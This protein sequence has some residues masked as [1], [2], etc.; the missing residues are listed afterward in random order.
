MPARPPSPAL[1]PGR[2]PG[3][4]RRNTASPMNTSPLAPSLPPCQARDSRTGTRWPAL[5]IAADAIVTA[6][7]SAAGA[8]RETGAGRLARV[9]GGAASADDVADSH[10]DRRSCG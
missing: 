4:D 1:A 6:V 5:A 3:H 2:F 8:L 9:D 10:R 7:R